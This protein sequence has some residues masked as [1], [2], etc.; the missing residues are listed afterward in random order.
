LDDG[1][2]G[3]RGGVLEARRRRAP[4]PES[5]KW[6]EQL[7]VSAA[8][9]CVLSPDLSP[10]RPDAASIPRR[11]DAL[12]FWPLRDS[13]TVFR[14]EAGEVHESETP[15]VASPAPQVRGTSSGLGPSGH[16]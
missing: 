5:L 1:H 4:R 11:W 14:R 13:P 10:E 8:W 2:A 12:E 6:R 7:G 3:V 16:T 9:A 15:H